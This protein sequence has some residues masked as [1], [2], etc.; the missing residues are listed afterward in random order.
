MG[1]WNSKMSRWVQ[2]MQNQ[3]CS[4]GQSG[5]HCC[6]R[7]VGLGDVKYE[8]HIGKQEVVFKALSL[9]S[10]TAIAGQKEVVAVQSVAVQVEPGDAIA[11]QDQQGVHDAIAIGE[12]DQ[13]QDKLKETSLQRRIRRLKSK[14]KNLQAAGAPLRPFN[15]SM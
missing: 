1:Y 13:G 9:L 11:D 4:C 3:N 6:P 5:F 12:V 8:V 7:T 14:K 2:D 10:G 15:R